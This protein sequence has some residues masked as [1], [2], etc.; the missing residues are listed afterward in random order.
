V[1]SCVT[2][3][4]ATGEESLRN[5]ELRIIFAATPKVRS[6]LAKLMLVVYWSM[7]AKFSVSPRIQFHVHI[8]VLENLQYVL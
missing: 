6:G 7:G 8:F 4:C 5:A 3:G 1:P 2:L